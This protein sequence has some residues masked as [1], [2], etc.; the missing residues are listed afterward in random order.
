MLKVHFDYFFQT[1]LAL[2]A[3]ALIAGNR[4]V[5]ICLLQED[6]YLQL[7]TNTDVIY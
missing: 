7:Q 1:V 6:A 3:M 5:F 4:L 2:Q